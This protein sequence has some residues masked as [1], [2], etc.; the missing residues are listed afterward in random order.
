MKR[1]THRSEPAPDA[2]EDRFLVLDRPGT[3]EVKEKG[4]RFLADCFPVES[5][6][7]AREQVAAIA[8]RHHDATHHPWALHLGHGDSA[9]RR[10]QDD[11]EPAGTAGA[12]IL[13]AIEGRGLSGTLVVVTRWFGGVKLGTSGLARCYGAAAAAALDAAPVREGYRQATIPFRVSHADLPA[14]QRVIFGAGGEFAEQAYGAEA[15]LVAS[16]RRSREVAVRQALVDA[17][18]GRVQLE[19]ES[20]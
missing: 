1:S 13:T 7:E 17:T 12:P 15:R 9:L 8:T 6:E 3:A 4:S 19:K 11:G 5:E 20:P 14:A 2:D 18:A 16:V 10:A